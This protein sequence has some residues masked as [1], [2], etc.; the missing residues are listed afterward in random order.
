MNPVFHWNASSNETPNRLSLYSVATALPT[1]SASSSCGAGSQRLTHRRPAKRVSAARRTNPKDSRRLVEPA[2]PVS[3][4]IRRLWAQSNDVFAAI[5]S[6]CKNYV[7]AAIYG[8]LS[9]NLRTSAQPAP[10]SGGAKER[11]GVTLP[12]SDEEGVSAT[13]RDDGRREPRKF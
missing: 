3:T 4:A 13:C 9:L 6:S 12:S 10:P 2:E 8:F 7:G 1:G 5:Y 11:T